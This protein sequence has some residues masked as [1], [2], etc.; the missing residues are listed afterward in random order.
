MRLHEFTKISGSALKT[1]VVRLKLKQVGYVQ[2]FDTTVQARTANQARQ[3]IRA[4]YDNKNVLVGQ[5]R[6][7]KVK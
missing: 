1:F 3:I 7:I 4:Q 2:Q 5:P 6:A